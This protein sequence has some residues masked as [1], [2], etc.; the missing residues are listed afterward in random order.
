MCVCIY[1]KKG[2]FKKKKKNKE[3]GTGVEYKMF[4]RNKH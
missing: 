3:T 1:L 2:D 4:F